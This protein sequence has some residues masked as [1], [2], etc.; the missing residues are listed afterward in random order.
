MYSEFFYHLL[1]FFIGLI[2]IVYAGEGFVRASV[3]IANIF[4]VPALYIGTFLIGFSTSVPEIL[5]TFLASQSGSVDLAIGNVLGSYICNIGFVIGISAL[6]KPLQISRETLEHSIPL[7]AISIITTALL[8]MIDSKF[9][10]LDGIILLVLFVGYLI[11][12]YLH[13]KKNKK[14]FTRDDVK[15][16]EH[17]KKIKSCIL[18][19]IF[20]LILLAGSHLMVISA[21]KIA[22]ILQINPLIVGLT[23]VAIGTSLPELTACIIAV[24]K[25]EHDIA[26]G[27]II[28]SNIFCLLCVLSIPLLMAPT[29]SISPE[30]LWI[31]MVMML[32]LTTALWLFSAKFDKTCQISRLEGLFLVCI[33]SI[34]LIYTINT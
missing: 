26:I 6:V 16:K 1:W 29:G 7:L 30:K 34:Y 10:Y 31:P 19:T 3:N 20:L 23:I 8:L 24:L 14:R 22:L 28:G 13:I 17:P 25:D 33:T 27:N 21:E 12:C 32:I 11:L 15:L 2:L 4:K 18:F 9:N 5:V